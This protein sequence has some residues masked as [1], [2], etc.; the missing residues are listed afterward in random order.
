MLDKF[1][2][3]VLRQHLMQNDG[4]ALIMNEE[5]E[6]TFSDRK[7]MWNTVPV[8]QRGLSLYQQCKSWFKANYRAE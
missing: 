1:T 4:V 2:E 8:V 6:D 3:A 7:R 5:M